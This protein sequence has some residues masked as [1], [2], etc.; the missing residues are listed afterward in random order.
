MM[1]RILLVFALLFFPACAVVRRNLT[2]VFP[3]AK[4]IACHSYGYCGPNAGAYMMGS[5]VCF[6]NDLST[7]RPI[8][9]KDSQCR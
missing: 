5:S 6:T 1:P 7:E 2:P 8:F 4:W 9:N 3:D